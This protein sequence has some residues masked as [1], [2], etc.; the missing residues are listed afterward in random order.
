MQSVVLL[1]FFPFTALP[2]CKT[3]TELADQLGNIETNQALSNQQ[4]L[5]KVIDLKKEFERC[6]LYKDSVYAKI[7]HRLGALQFAAGKYE[8][9]I[10]NTIQAIKIN[11]SGK[12]ESSRK[13]AVVSYFNLGFCYQQLRLYNEALDNYDKCI[14]LG[15]EYRDASIIDR[16]IK[17]RIKK[18]NIVYR[19]G[20]YEKDVDEMSIGLKSAA[21][22]KD[23][24]VV[25][26]LLN[27]RAQAYVALKRIPEAINDVQKALLFVSKEDYNAYANNY[28]IRAVIYQVDNNF[29]LAIAYHKKAIISRSQTGDSSILATD[30]NDAGNTLIAAKRY[31]EA[32]KY[33]NQSLLLAEKTG[34]RVTA[35]KASNNLGLVNVITRKY[36]VALT[37][38]QASLLKTVPTF[39][40]S[41]ELENPTYLQCN[42]ISDKNFLALLL[43]NKTECL[44]YLYKL[45]G[46]QLYLSTSLKTARL[47]D[48]IITDVRHAQSGEQSKL[49][50]RNETREFFTNAIEACYQAKDA[51]QAFFFMEKSRAVL[52]NDR[53]NELGASAYLPPEEAHKE[54][55]LQMNVFTLQQQLSKIETTDP[56]FEEQQ[57]NLLRAKEGQE[58][59]IKTLQN[60]YPAYYQ[61][62]YADD[63]PQLAQFTKYLHVNKQSFVHYFINDTTVYMLGIT[64][65]SSKLIKLISPGFNESLSEFLRMCSDMQALNNHYS[66]FALLSHKI[67][68]T[69]FK[70]LDLPKGKT[71]ICYD[72]FLI[73]FEALTTDEKGD[74]F[75]LNNYAFSYIYSARFLLKNFNNPRGSGNFLGVAPVSYAGYLHVPQLM[76]SE[77]SLNA[78]ASNFRTCK[79]ITNGEANRN[80]FLKKL[81]KYTIVTILSHA[82]A[83][84]SDK[85]PIL[86]MADSVIRL[87]E[88]QLLHNPSTQLIVLSAC[89]TNVGKIATGEGVISLARGFASAGIPS[90]CAT[91]WK[92][93][94]KAIYEI[95]EVFLQNISKGMRKDDALQN[96]KLAFI[97]SGG[98]EKLF[99][100][101]WANMILA[102]NGEPVNFSGTGHGTVWLTVIILAVAAILFLVIAVK[103]RKIIV[104]M[105]NDER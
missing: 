2:Q 79:L 31:E 82:R 103:R 15:N 54:Q 20:D 1:A 37:E 43:G 55:L 28:K 76:Q 69:L 98:N 10:N 85:E 12:K 35:A 87:S 3:N 63:I 74:D 44:L 104:K 19:N 38:Y 105:R 48:S 7:L 86:F 96:A 30:Y 17:A 71:I 92:A 83:D 75:L 91:L 36:A 33:L 89:Q 93:D 60:K 14:S 65:S 72:N 95:S 6:K 18:G 45:T 58:K 84:T 47:T 39:I 77:T 53:L 46:N 51:K 90:I 32:G 59:Y 41:D 100:Y 81:P 57:V 88:L 80:N 52:L 21:I 9:A 8:D 26:D 23:S 61:Y 16:V 22:I 102:G 94:E 13:F 11:T 24:A 78:S 42:A 4:R 73:P 68:E 40:S 49:Y 101:Y 70:P 62:K 99:P 34:N 27:E 64:A 29:P 67:Y 25:V 50:W 56:A 97:R 5:T 66:A